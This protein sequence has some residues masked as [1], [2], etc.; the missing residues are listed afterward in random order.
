LEELFALFPKAK[1]EADKTAL[2]ISLGSENHAMVK[3]LINQK[4]AK[5]IQKNGARKSRNLPEWV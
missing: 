3:R 1:E 2:K 4:L 5:M